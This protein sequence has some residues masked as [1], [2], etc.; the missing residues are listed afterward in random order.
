[1]NQHV[2]VINPITKESVHLRLKLLTV[3]PMLG[4]FKHLADT[5]HGI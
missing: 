2:T 3:A 1:M 5:N 4:V